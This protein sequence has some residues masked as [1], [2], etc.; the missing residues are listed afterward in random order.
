MKLHRTFVVTI[1]ASL[2]SAA[3][4]AAQTKSAQPATGSGSAAATTKTVTYVGCLEPGSGDG[5]F[6]LTNAD[7][8][9]TKTS[10][11]VY[12]KVVPSSSKVKLED[13]ITQS[14]EITGT[15]TD[16]TPPGNASTS[17][18]KLPTFSATNVKWQNDYCG[19]P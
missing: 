19:L 4:L 1:G 14:V 3:F 16:S 17:S 18:E 2:M 15:F 9:G 10:E 8:K 5:N 6:M 13:H 7:E 12:F 11:H